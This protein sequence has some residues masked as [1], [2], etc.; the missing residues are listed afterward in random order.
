MADI[1]KTVR[2]AAE[3]AVGL[4]VMGFQRAQVRRREME[5]RLER[6]APEVAA[7]VERVRQ[8]VSRLARSVEP[9]LAP[10]VGQV[11]EGIDRVEAHLPQPAR[12]LL[13][14][15]REEARRQVRGARERFDRPSS[16][17][18]AS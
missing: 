5:R 14:R 11:E 18:G 15:T 13:A 3:V 6:S 16:P 17:G 9:V 1:P 2:G 4:G 12:Q 7:S 8:D 10:L